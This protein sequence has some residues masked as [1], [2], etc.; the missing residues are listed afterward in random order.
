MKAAQP[1]QQFRPARAYQLMPVRF[2]LFDDQRIILTSMDGAYEILAESVA[3][4]FLAHQL[5]AEEPAYALLQAKGFL[6]DDLTP[7]NPALLATRLRSRWQYLDR[8][9]GLFIFV[10]TLRC[11]HTCS[12]CQVSRKNSAESTAF[13][14]SREDARAALAQIKDSPAE[15]IK[16]EFQGG[17]PLLNFPLIKMIV[18]EA[19]AGIDKKISFVIATSLSCLDDDMLDFCQRHSIYIST[20]LDGPAGI[21]DSNRKLP[22]RSSYDLTI[23]QIT[24]VRQRLGPDSVS[25]LMTFNPRHAASWRDIVDCYRNNGFHQIFYRWTSPYGFARENLTATDAW[26]ALYEQVL[27]YIID[28]NKGGGHFVEIYSQIVLSKILANRP[29]LYADLSN[30]TSLGLGV[31]VFNYDGGIYP[32]DESRML[33][34]TG[35]DS[36]RLGHV[37]DLSFADIYKSEVLQGIAISSQLEA[38]PSCSSCPF[39]PWCGS[40]PVYHHTVQGDLRG[41]MRSSAFCRRN[42]AVYKTLLR[43]LEDPEIRNIFLRWVQL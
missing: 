38:S 7:H 21:H 19:T 9:P 39:L 36:F 32:S 6:A 13:D 31:L 33:K 34:E 14:M 29:N 37:Q 35:D 20:S 26:L 23:A 43:R 24:R 42:M 28:I 1:A 16:I 41:D 40:D 5:E 27:D 18:E 30:P 25:A 15:H 4:R 3:R 8:G 11:E 2:D 17:E 10:V 12:Y 22:G